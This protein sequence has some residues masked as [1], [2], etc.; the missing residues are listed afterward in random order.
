MIHKQITTATISGGILLFLFDG[1]FQAIPGLGVRAV[2]RLETNGLTTSDF[3]VLI[4]RMSYLV[5]DNTVSF[6]ATK[7]ADYYD[8][9]R[10]FAVE[11]IS[12]LSIALLFAFIFSKVRGL[13]LIDRLQFTMCFALVACFAIHLPYLNWWGFSWAY[14]AGVVLKTI[15]GWLLVAFVQNR[16]IFKIR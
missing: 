5:T 4:N 15:L 8:L 14:T 12:A 6:I 11:F 10:F 2:E 9:P 13:S 1:A 3:S 7:S 16:F